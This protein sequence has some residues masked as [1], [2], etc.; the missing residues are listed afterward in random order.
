[1][2][3]AV[4]LTWIRRQVQQHRPLVVARED[5]GRA[6]VALAMRDGPSGAEVLL[7]QRAERSGDPW[8]GHMALP[9]GRQEPGDRDLY[10]TAARET[11]EEVGIDL[12]AAG[13]RL[14][15][16]D[17]MQAVGRGKVLPL[18]ITPVA[19]ELTSAVTL[20]LNPAEARDAVWIPLATLRGSGSHGH[21]QYELDGFVTRHPAF[22]YDRYT[23]W[24]ITYRIL[25]NLL[26]LTAR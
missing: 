14:G 24:G 21:Y 22:T 15:H 25:S 3:G 20:R 4:D 12:D 26:S 13:H 16:L 19:W 11:S 2:F 8:S 23:I 17:E 1:M 18:V 10:A 5:V 6:A 9:G 7:I